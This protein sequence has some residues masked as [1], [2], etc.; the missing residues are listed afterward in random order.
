MNADFSDQT[1]AQAPLPI[2]DRVKSAAISPA[3]SRT[4][5]LE[6]EGGAKA[7]ARVKYG[8]RHDVPMTNPERLKRQGEIFNHSGHCGKIRL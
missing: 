7:V 5:P 6:T 1:K 3:Q 4:A 8:A 2:A